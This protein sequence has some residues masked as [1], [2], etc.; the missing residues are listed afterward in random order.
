MKIII[1]FSKPQMHFQFL[2]KMFIT[3]TLYVS[4]YQSY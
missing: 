3:K 4:Y 2:I 1:G